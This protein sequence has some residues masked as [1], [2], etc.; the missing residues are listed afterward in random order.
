MGSSSSKSQK[1]K[2]NSKN[3]QDMQQKRNSRS[4]KMRTE[5][6][7]TQNVRTDVNQD[8]GPKGRSTRETQRKPPEGVKKPRRRKKI[9]SSKKK[10]ATLSHAQIEELK[11]K[12]KGENVLTCKQSKNVVKK[13]E[14]ETLEPRKE[15]KEV[16]CSEKLDEVKPSPTSSVESPQ[17]NNKENFNTENF[18]RSVDPV[19]KDS[20][21][22]QKKHVGFSEFKPVQIDGPSKYQED[23]DDF[24]AWLESERN[25]ELPPELLSSDEDEPVKKMIRS[26]KSMMPIRSGNVRRLAHKFN[27]LSRQ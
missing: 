12:S 1:I 19:T 3:M 15:G 25:A 23:N 11:K 22:Q 20:S 7:N 14:K 21:T 6:D 27:T 18:S 26:R 10:P 5:R 24:E 17:F 16:D 4:S 13:V 2:Q 9:N 8:K